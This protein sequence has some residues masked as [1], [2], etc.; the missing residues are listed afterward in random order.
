VERGNVSLEEAM[1]TF[2]SGN[3]TISFSHRQ[4]NSTSHWACYHAR[5]MSWPLNSWILQ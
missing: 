1:N 5:A 2:C 3:W 4:W